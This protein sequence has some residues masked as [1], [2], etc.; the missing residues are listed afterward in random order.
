MRYSSDRDYN[1]EEL[2][3]NLDHVKQR[4]A[5]L[6]GVRAEEV[7]FPVLDHKLRQTGINV[8][9]EHLPRCDR[10]GWLD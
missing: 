3:T 6:V 10:K 7:R 1:N 4:V 9:I 5:G 2:L 8:V